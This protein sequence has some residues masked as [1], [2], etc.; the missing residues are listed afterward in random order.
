VIVYGKIFER[1]FTGTMYGSGPVVFAVWAYVIANAR[2]PGVVSLNPK[3]LAS[4]I[5]CS[6]EEIREA[7]EF[8]M[9]PDPES[10]T[11]DEQGRRLVHIGSLDYH[12]V[13]WQKY[14][15]MRDEDERREYQ[16][17]WINEKRQRLRAAT[18]VDKSRHEST[19]VDTDQQDSTKVD[20]RQ[21]LTMSTKAEAEAEAVKSRGRAS[22]F[23]LSELPA[24]WAA[25][26]RSERQDLDPQATFDR[27]GDYW[28][29]KPGKD[30]RK[31]DWL[32][33]WRN[34]VRNERAPPPGERAGSPPQEKPWWTPSP[35]VL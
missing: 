24:D 12:V 7:I 21:M 5:G 29:A 4:T 10:A 27:F 17:N 1:M 16:R 13:S 19:T 23:L 15:D 11:T 18:D 35:T 8:L 31:V 30:G 32:A 34:W 28:R 33:T 26:C 9:R 25:W 14:R 6:T 20:C 3:L 2:P 22:R